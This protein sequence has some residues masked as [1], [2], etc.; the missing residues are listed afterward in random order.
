MSSKFNVS[1]LNSVVE[2]GWNIAR[3][4]IDYDKFNE[5][6]LSVLREREQIYDDTTYYLKALW[7]ISKEITPDVIYNKD[8]MR[9]AIEYIGRKNSIGE[10]L[11]TTRVAFAKAYGE[12][13]LIYLNAANAGLYEFPRSYRIL[14]KRAAKPKVKKK[15]S[16]ASKVA[17]LKFSEKINI[18]TIDSSALSQTEI[19][20]C[21]KDGKKFIYI[22]SPVQSLL[23]PLESAQVINISLEN[24]INQAKKLGWL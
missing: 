23:I 6:M 17:P 12:N 13:N 7:T 3:T 22:F 5:N 20:L 11:K 18:A 14:V 10:N 1:Y 24:A 19:S 15:T 8:V 4:S 21:N 16:S 2:V 9:S